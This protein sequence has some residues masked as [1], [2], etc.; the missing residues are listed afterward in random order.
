M[1]QSLYRIV[2]FQSRT[3]CLSQSDAA[4]SVPDSTSIVYF[5]PER[6]AVVIPTWIKE[7]YRG[8]WDEFQS[9]TGCLSHSDQN[10]QVNS[11]VQAGMFQSRTGWGLVIST[12]HGQPVVRPA[13]VSIPDGN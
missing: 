1:A 2:V 8:I 3:G 10:F 5:N 13:W 4:H 7:H 9:R 6:K 12:H 11:N